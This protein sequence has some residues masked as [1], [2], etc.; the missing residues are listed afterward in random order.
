MHQNLLITD[1]RSAMW[2]QNLTVRYRNETCRRTQPGSSIH[3]FGLLYI[4]FSDI[5]ASADCLSP[6]QNGVFPAN[7]LQGIPP[8]DKETRSDAQG[9]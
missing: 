9:T 5:E 6:A 7:F 4:K 2:K 1:A 8:G 3:R